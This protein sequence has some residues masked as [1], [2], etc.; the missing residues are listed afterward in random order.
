MTTPQ[1]VDGSKDITRR[2]GWW[3]LKPGDRVRAV[4]KAMGLK[5][6]EKIE[7]LG[8]IEIVSVRAEPL[9][10]MLDDLDYGFDE[11]RREGFPFGTQW[12]SVFVEAICSHYHATPDKL[13]NRIEFKKVTNPMEQENGNGREQPRSGDAA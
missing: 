9:Q 13:C 4:K 12:P 3:N 8:I 11:V 5:K 7:E 2:F 10:A 1:F 6:G